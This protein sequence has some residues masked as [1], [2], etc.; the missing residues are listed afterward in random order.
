MGEEGHAS[1]SAGLTDTPP[2]FPH[3]GMILFTHIFRPARGQRMMSNLRRHGLQ[4]RPAAAMLRRQL[5]TRRLALSNA[6]RQP[7]HGRR[8]GSLAP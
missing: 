2:L 7:D 3:K 6:D 4:L 5:K 1:P 8:L